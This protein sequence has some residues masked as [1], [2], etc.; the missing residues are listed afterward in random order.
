MNNKLLDTRALTG[1]RFLAAAI[2]VIFHYGKDVDLVSVLG[3]GFMTAGPQMVGFFFVLSGFILAYVYLQRQE[4]RV[5]EYMVARFARIVP[6]Y[7]LALLALFYFRPLDYWQ[8]LVDVT[9]LKAWFPQFALGGNPPAWSISVELFFYAIFPF[10][11]FV[12]RGMKFSV[13]GFSSFSLCFWLFSQ[14]VLTNLFYSDF[15][16]GGGRFSHGLIFY[17]PISHLSNF[18]MGM[19]VAYILVTHASVLRGRL[20]TGMSVVAGAILA[21]LIYWVLNERVASFGGFRVLNAAGG[22]APLYAVFIFSVVL[23]A[24]VWSW[25]FGNRLAIFLGESSYALYILQV[26]VFLAFSKYIAP[27]ISLSNDTAFWLYFLVLVVVSSLVFIFFERPIRDSL[28]GVYKR[29]SL[30]REQ[31]SVA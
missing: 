23:S 22:L 1:L 28:N 3:K 5:G 10:L 13:A 21:A 16:K 31:F 27:R 20:V 25:L 26:P 11:I 15:Y 17:F 14:L 24:G 18:F 12:I 19:A 4:F 2:V 8:F 30:G 29:C 9:L 6:V 7:M